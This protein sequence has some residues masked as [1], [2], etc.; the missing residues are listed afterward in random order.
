MSVDMRRKRSASRPSI[1]GGV[2]EGCTKI[3]ENEEKKGTER[4]DDAGGGVV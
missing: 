3:E 2:C 1:D 4:D